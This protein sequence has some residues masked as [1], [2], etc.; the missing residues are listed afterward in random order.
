MRT[1]FISAAAAATLFASLSFAGALDTRSEFASI[2]RQQTQDPSQDAVSARDAA[3]Y[4]AFDYADRFHVQFQLHT[5]VCAIATEGNASCDARVVAARG[6]NPGVTLMTP[7]GY[8]PAQFLKAYG[9]SGVS[10]ATKPPVIAIVDA[11][12]D[13]NIAKDLATYS[14]QFGIPQ[15]PACKGAVASSA[16]PCFQ[17][18]GQTGS[19]TRFPFSNSGWALEISLDVETAH[20]ICQNCSILLVEANSSSYMQPDGRYRPRGN[21]RR[22]SGFQ[23]LRLRRILR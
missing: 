18:M 21:K 3:I 19:T 6:S 15:L 22:K 7:S 11:Y 12:D 14:T 4:Q 13:P 2:F 8:G 1:L 16:T 9:L 20:A 10:S 5:R 23:F 17:K